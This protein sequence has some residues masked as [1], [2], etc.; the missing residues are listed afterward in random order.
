MTQA[1]PAGVVLT[2]LTYDNSKHQIWLSGEARDTKTV[3]R[4]LKNFEDSP[5]FK[6]TVLIEARKAVIQGVQ[7]VVFKIT[8]NLT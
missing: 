2:N 4:L 3:G 7:K 8:F 1:L 5:S 6:R